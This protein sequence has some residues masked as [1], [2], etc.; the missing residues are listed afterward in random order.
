MSPEPN[1]H[2][3]KSSNADP[4]IRRGCAGCL[5]FFALGLVVFG[6][7]L[8]A[9][10]IIGSSSQVYSHHE[11]RQN[12]DFFLNRGTPE[13]HPTN[14]N[15][16]RETDTPFFKRVPVYKTVHHTMG[17]RTLAGVFGFAL[18]VCGLL[19]WNSA[20]KDLQPDKISGD[21]S[22]TP[23]GGLQGA[24][25][26]AACVV[27]AF[28]MYTS[29]S[30][31]AS[32]PKR[33]PIDS[34]AT[35]PDDATRVESK[36]GESSPRAFAESQAPTSPQAD[37]PSLGTT[38]TLPKELKD[39]KPTNSDTT[40]T[41]F[42]QLRLMSTDG[43]EIRA[44]VIAVSKTTVIVRREDG[45]EFEIALERLSPDSRELIEAYRAAKRGARQQF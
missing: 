5:V 30:K 36:S 6:V 3:I 11:I 43:R 2:P 12:P 41:V 31:E 20:R 25:I 39:P 32:Y 9:G 1:N 40:Q 42:G 4:N 34:V 37:A 14:P 29:A 33:P 24:I 44:T 17:E 28:W 8:V 15:L 26:I 7:G 10:N 35:I 21:V 45:Q 16:V 18:I 27:I 38:T 13:F 22:P 23:S 19:I